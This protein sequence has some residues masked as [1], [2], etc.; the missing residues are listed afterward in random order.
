MA[1]AEKWVV[2][3]ARAA[4]TAAA[5][6]VKQQLGSTSASS[7]VTVASSSSSSTTTTGGEVE[8]SCVMEMGVINFRVHASKRG[9]FSLRTAP[10]HFSFLRALCFPG[11]HLLARRR[12]CPPG[13]ARRATK[14]S[15]A[16][17]PSKRRTSA[18]PTLT[19]SACSCARRS[20]SRSQPFPSLP[21][22]PYQPLVSPLAW[23]NVI[24]HPSSI[25]FTFSLTENQE[26][27][28]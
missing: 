13:T 14:W 4:A 1:E 22:P 28:K 26:R 12:T 10:F 16:A 23:L 27:C 15:A 18:S 19:F 25:P 20:S 8:F 6:A 3:K 21:A 17:C 24:H 5:A 2:E 7:S 9:L 11:S